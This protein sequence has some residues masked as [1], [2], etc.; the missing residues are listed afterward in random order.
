MK[1]Q[2][3][4]GL[5][6]KQS[7]KPTCRDW[8]PSAQQSLTAA[9]PHRDQSWAWG[10]HP[11]QL[12]PYQRSSGGPGG[13]PGAPP[14]CTA[15]PAEGPVPDQA[16]FGQMPLQHLCHLLMFQLPINSTAMH[17]DHQSRAH[18]VGF[19]TLQLVS[20]RH[21]DGVCRAKNVQVCK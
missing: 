20:D 4:K 13:V 14:A 19:L 9:D 5:T 7:P 16:C 15:V 3:G 1:T 12:Q 11:P 10:P 8:S 17:A 18:V 21:W 2:I 6:C